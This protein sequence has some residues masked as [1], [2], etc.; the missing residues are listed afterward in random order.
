MRTVR[1]FHVRR[2]R[3][4][5]VVLALLFAQAAAV[6]SA[7][8]TVQVQAPALPPLTL[9]RSDAHWK[10]HRGMNSPPADWKT[11][12]DEALGWS[13]ARGGFGFAPDNPNETIHC[14]TILNDMFNRYSTVYIR[15]SFWL[16][17]PPSAD[18]R[19]LLTVD[20]D[21]GFVAY[22]DGLEVAR[23]NAPGNPGAELASSAVATASHESS[24]GNPESSPEQART[25]DLGPAN[26]L[27]Q[28]NHVLA[29]IGLNRAIDSTDFILVADLIL[30][31]AREPLIQLGNYSLVKTN[32]VIL[33]GTNDFAYS[34]RV[35]VNGLEAAFHLASGSFQHRQ[36]LKPGINPFFIAA[37]DTEGEIL[38]ATNILILSEP[39]STEVGGVIATNTA[40]GGVIHIEADV[41]VAPG[42]TL[43]IA[44]GTV[45]LFPPEAGITAGTNSTVNFAGSPEMPVYLLPTMA[46][47]SW[48]VS[49]VG[50]DAL[51][52]VQNVE[53][54][55]GQMLADYGGT[56]IRVDAGVPLAP[57]NLR[58]LVSG[59]NH[60]ELEWE[61]GAG[62]ESFFEVERSEDTESW[63]QLGLVDQSSTSFVDTTADLRRR[64]LYRVRAR[65][66]NGAS[67]W[68][69]PAAGI[70]ADPFSPIGGVMARDL[71]WTP[72][73]GSM[74]VTED[75]IVPTNRVLKLA[76]GTRVSMT[77]G[78]SLLAL[79]GGAIQI[80][81]ER[82]NAVTISPAV[83]GVFWGELSAKGDG[84]SLAARFADISGGQTTVYSN[85]VGLLEDSYFHDYRRPGGTLF[86]AP[87]VLSSFA[88]EMTLRRCH[89]SEYHETLFRD[90]VITIEEC[91]FEYCSGDGLDFDGAQSGTVLRRSTFR[92]GTR[93]PSNIDAVDVGPGALGPCRDV[94]I[95]DCVIYDFPTDKGVS[96]GDAPNQAIGTIVRNSLIYDCHAG[97]QV[98][99]GAFAEVYQCTIVFNQWGV[100]NYNKANPSS[101]NGGGNITNAH[102]NILWGNGVT[103]SMWNGGSLTADHSNF[104]D[105]N[106][107]GDS[108]ILQDPQFVDPSQGDYR[109]GPHSPSRGSG[110]NGADMGA[111][112]PVGSPQAPSHPSFESV[113]MAGNEI[114]LRFWADSERRY[115]IESTPALTGAVW[116]LV[117]EIPAPALPKL[118]EVMVSGTESLSFY[119]VAGVKTR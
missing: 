62:G 46:N 118:T 82:E 119:R 65:N 101:A 34:T 68:S 114:I 9:A 91:L 37:L 22:L 74:L 111:R 29:V 115:K 1:T 102:N 75:L 39:G 27:S 81:G 94:I 56:L 4:S 106:W 24:L 13:T 67:P 19:L 105:T 87:L 72:R 28:G 43:E 30:T 57:R 71:E 31:G 107:P 17:T 50:P 42:A 23:S 77:N 48:S 60:I 45:I 92:H 14:Q 109:L 85:A 58:A 63:I 54:L 99:D 79:D 25:F 44:A 98:K 108:N 70:R 80:N 5:S 21:D 96:I 32:T 18:H 90:G 113:H 61:R 16:D 47:S 26:R 6:K 40:W 15:Q 95:E 64:Y 78:A 117:A 55:G 8:L 103:I 93:A 89:L 33:S 66:S 10:F 20:W 2:I 76:P 11:A 52:R 51:L 12:D 112:F 3:S 116:S 73:M 110:R 49:A 86:T 97:V 104:G 83:P 36:L 69:N 84:A 53:S 41:L 7:Q 59:T 88:R 35:T 38:G 100:T